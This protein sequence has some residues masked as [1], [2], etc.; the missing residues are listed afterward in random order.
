MA[1]GRSVLSSDGNIVAIGAPGDN[2]ST[3]HIGN[4]GPTRVYEKS[5]SGWIQLGQDINGNGT[6]EGF[7]F[8]V[9]A[10]GDGTTLAIGV[11]FNDDN[12][13]NAGKVEIYKL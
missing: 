4:G 13:S 9:S 8:S 7:G 12:V 5:S 2:L 3:S 10:K 11:P 1:S 6:D